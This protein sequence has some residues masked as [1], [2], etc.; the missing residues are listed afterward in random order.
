MT[1]HGPVHLDQSIVIFIAPLDVYQICKPIYECLK[2]CSNLVGNGNLRTC[3]PPC[4]L[5]LRRD[6]FA[7]LTHVS[8]YTKI[9]TG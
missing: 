2:C 3:P 9:T 1:K 8:T 4:K 5:V 6:F 7:I